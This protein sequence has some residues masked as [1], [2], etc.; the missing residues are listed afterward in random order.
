MA[1]KRQMLLGEDDQWHWVENKNEYLLND[2]SYG[3][4]TRFLYFPRKPY[5][6]TAL[7]AT[8]GSIW[9][10]GAYSGRAGEAWEFGKLEIALPIKEVAAASDDFL[11]LA[12]NGTVSIVPVQWCRI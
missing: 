4:T 3:M 12:N 1:L 11:A 10:L 2:L 8:D 7:L 5:S 9:S 6:L